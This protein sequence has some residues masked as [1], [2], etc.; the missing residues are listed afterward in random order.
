MRLQLC[1]ILIGISTYSFSQ[2]LEKERVRWNKS[3]TKDSAYIFNKQ[4]NALLIETIKNKKPGTALDI[5]MGQGRNSL[6]LA[7]NGWKV[8]GFD[9]ADEAVAFAK[10]Q[11]EK[12]KIKINTLISTREEF[13][14][15]INRWDL[16]TYIYEGCMDEELIKKIKNSLKPHGVIVF[17]FFHR[18]AGI[19]MGRPAFGCESNATKQLLQNARDF[20]IIQYEETEDIADFGLKKYKLVKLVAERK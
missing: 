1:F 20:R 8:T 15:G 7:R 13:D 9:I 19:K 18:E 16:V 6:H 14:Y 17:E 11:A 3:L 4:P 5:G 12:E 2:D 10:K